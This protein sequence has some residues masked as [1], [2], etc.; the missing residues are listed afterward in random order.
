MLWEYLPI[1]LLIACFKSGI[2][3]NCIT[4][5]KFYI[6]TQISKPY[7]IVIYFIIKATWVLSVIFNI[8]NINVI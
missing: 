1:I 5:Y 8:F 6:L 4:V 3:I 7:N 2:I